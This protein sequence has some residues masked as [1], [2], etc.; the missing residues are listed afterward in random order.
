MS[1]ASLRET[2]SSSKIGNVPPGPAKRLS[3]ILNWIMNVP[4]LLRLFLDRRE[5]AINTGQNSLFNYGTLRLPLVSVV[6][7]NNGNTVLNDA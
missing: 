7:N 4:P 5:K 1:M 2:S 3:A 6:S